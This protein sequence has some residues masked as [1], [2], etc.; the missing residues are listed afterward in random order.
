MDPWIETGP[1]RTTNS[2]PLV[3]I[4]QVK[5]ATSN[6]NH[7]QSW[8]TALQYV[9]RV[10]RDGWYDSFGQFASNAAAASS[11]ELMGIFDVI[12]QQHSLYRLPL[13]S[14]HLSSDELSSR[15]D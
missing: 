6:I 4:I 13:T 7:K 5:L 2:D 14:P 9:Q 10:S 8:S 15:S 1:D 3:K 12:R 11:N